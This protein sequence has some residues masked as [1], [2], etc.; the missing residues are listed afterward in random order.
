MNFAVM[1]SQ[2]ELKWQGKSYKKK[3]EKREMAEQTM[4]YKSINYAQLNKY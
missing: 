3:E 1:R 2:R 4:P